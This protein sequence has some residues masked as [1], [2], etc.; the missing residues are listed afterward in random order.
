MER[1]VFQSFFRG[2][3]YDSFLGSKLCSFFQEVQIIGNI[4][5]CGTSKVSGSMIW[6]HQTE[7]S[8][9]VKHEINMTQIHKQK[10]KSICLQATRSNPTRIQY[11]L[12]YCA[13]HP[14]G[15]VL[16][17]FSSNLQISPY[18]PSTYNFKGQFLGSSGSFF[19]KKAHPKCVQLNLC[20]RIHLVGRQKDGWKTMTLS[21]LANGN[22][23]WNVPH[24][25]KRASKAGGTEEKKFNTSGYVVGMIQKCL[26]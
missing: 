12:T 18:P 17:I 20:A 22:A 2:W 24:K 9:H 23:I 10:P 14:S 13:T 1:I 19:Q 15:G 4:D 25:N 21:S 7:I 8:G 3:G 11:A 5:F 26:G 6:L 16:C